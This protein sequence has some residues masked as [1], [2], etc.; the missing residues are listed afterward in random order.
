MKHTVT[1][2]NGVQVPALGL[3]TWFLGEN[4]AARAREMESLRTGISAGMTLIDTAEMYGNGKAESLI[5]EVIS[6]K[7]RDDLFLVS[8]VLPNNAGKHRL[9]QA[10][11]N[12][13]KRMGVE[14]LDLYLYHWR[15]NYPLEETVAELDRVKKAG[16]IKEWGVSNFDIDDMQQNMIRSHM[17]PVFLERPKYKESVALTIADK[18]VATHEMYRY[19]LADTLGIWMIFLFNVISIQK[20]S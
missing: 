8:K 4:K 10:L 9:E 14:Y 1:L 17:F 13:M 15:G 19:K 18:V 12:S 2:R 3:G 11:D 7:K 20:W 5:K 16:K 6:D